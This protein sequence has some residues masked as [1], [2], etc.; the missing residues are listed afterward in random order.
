VAKQSLLL[1]DGDARSLRVLEVSLKKA[2]F[3]VTTSDNGR[4]AIEKVAI[5]PPDLI[6]SD[7]DMDEMDGFAFCSQLKSHAEW[8]SIPFIFLTGQTGIEHKIRGLELGVEDYLTKPI[9]IKEIL[10]RV[11]I[12]L[13]K[14]QRATLEEKREGR[15]RFAGRLTDMGVVDLIQTIEI[16]RKS[17]LIHLV[18]ESGRR[19]E[20]YFRDGKVIDAEAGPLQGEDAVYRLLTWNEGEFEVA[21]R[22]VRRRDV[23]QVSSQ[24][25]LMEGMRRLDE[26][27][28]LLEQLPA[29]DT[30]YEVDADELAVR[31]SELPDELNAILKLFDGNRT[32]MEVIDASSF[33]DLETLSIISKLYF[34]GLLGEAPGDGS[35]AGEAELG[36]GV[37]DGWIDSGPAIAATPATGP[38]RASAPA[39]P[40]ADVVGSPLSDVPDEVPGPVARPLAGLAASAVTPGLERRLESTPS[41]R[42][43]ALVELAIDAAT[44]VVSMPLPASPPARGGIQVDDGVPHEIDP[45]DKTPPEPLRAANG[46][47]PLVSMASLR[48]QLTSSLILDELE[49]TDEFEGATP[50]PPPMIED[51]SGPRVVSSLGADAASASGELAGTYAPPRAMTAR[52]LV[53]IAPRRPSEQIAVPV[54][55]I[56]AAA[57]RTASA[58]PARAASVP[59]VASASAP[60]A[61]RAPTVPGS[62]PAMVPSTSVSA[63]KRP[64]KPTPKPAARPA[65]KPTPKPAPPLDEDPA[66]R[67]IPLWPA[68]AILGAGAVVILVLFLR[69]GDSPARPGADAALARDA[70][71]A[72]VVPVDATAAAVPDDAT[73]AAV[74]DDAAAAAVPDDATGRR[75][76]AAAGLRDAG[77][78]VHLGLYAQAN[79][80]YRKK[81]FREAAELAEASVA[82]QRTL[83]AVQLL[84]QALLAAGDYEPAEAAI[85]VAIG[86][87]PRSAV[88]WYW[89]GK[90][91]FA[92]GDRTGARA[93]FEKSLELKPTG[94][95]ADELRLILDRI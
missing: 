30:R 22:S 17:G 67:P 23:I 26:W 54:A 94:A 92:R 86:M 2:G 5:A 91:V 50:I 85:D 48:P 36:D 13:E 53:T 83:K 78:E 77:G 58:P 61:S 7:T 43:L 31:L 69:R 79:A 62:R 42:V 38:M 81:K 90:I 66:S 74:P 80:A 29:L 76:A 37:R 8:S 3:N 47:L 15:T 55:A 20:L 12:L 70:G 33:G 60:P 40:E 45:A 28:R 39:A 4:D 56:E 19:A 68:L 14:R 82:A 89:K 49:G 16:S 9:Y 34:E 32:L 63:P 93:A 35:S 18:S 21:F 6:I 95:V 10:T 71:L 87:A 41:E 25:L 73:A 44:P 75:D 72:A 84:A 27:G 88:A 65:L 1:V 46:R 64:L 11:R 52:E 59:P 57:P 51:A 24:G